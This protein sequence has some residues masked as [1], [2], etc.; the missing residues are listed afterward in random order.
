MDKER[1]QE[2]V[3]DAVLSL[4]VCS[5]QTYADVTAPR[6][7]D[8]ITPAN[9]DKE[10]DKSHNTTS[11]NN[12]SKGLKQQRRNP[13]WWDR[14]HP[15][16]K[17]YNDHKAALDIVQNGPTR[18]LGMKRATSLT[19][20]TMTTQLYQHRYHHMVRKQVA[21]N[22]NNAMRKAIA[23][24]E[25]GH[26]AESER[27]LQGDVISRIEGGEQQL[28]P[29]AQTEALQE[30]VRKANATGHH[31]HLSATTPMHGAELN[32]QSAEV[33]AR[34][35][36]EYNKE[37]KAQIE[38]GQARV[39]MVEECVKQSIP[40]QCSCLQPKITIDDNGIPKG[41]EGCDSVHCRDMS[42]KSAS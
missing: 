13:H 15:I 16:Q 37:K 42:K 32:E 11:S 9:N 28:S 26:A 10:K 25:N 18:L 19:L 31:S 27:I 4:V 35:V 36:N 1:I 39:K 21:R 41:T 38:A 20:L 7:D 40:P 5:W 8:P 12:M 2:V 34:N 17:R 3:N 14:H 33:F 22:I 23:L 30:M 29:T 6:S 24:A